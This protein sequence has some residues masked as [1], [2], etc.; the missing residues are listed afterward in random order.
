M[1]CA[2]MGH[3]GAAG[4]LGTAGCRSRLEARGASRLREFGLERGES[5]MFQEE[6][7]LLAGRVM[8]SAPHGADF[9]IRL[10]DGNASPKARHCVVIV[11]A[12]AGIFALEICRDP[13]CG[14]RRKLKCLWEDAPNGEE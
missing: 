14:V 10:L 11:R 4:A 5:C 7:A 12:S 9:G 2:T 1:N 6:G 3:L 8:N 13:E